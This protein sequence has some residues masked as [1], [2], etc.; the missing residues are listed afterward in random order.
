MRSTVA[1]LLTT[2]APL[3]SAATGAVEVWMTDCQPELF[4]EA[5]P[6]KIRMTLCGLKG[7]TGRC[8]VSS[9]VPLL[10]S[11]PTSSVSSLALTV[12][13]AIKSVFLI[14]FVSDVAAFVYTKDG[15]IRLF[16]QDN[17]VWRIHY[18]CDA[19]PPRVY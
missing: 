12:G 1:L 15:Y 18:S 14:R 2:L 16:V 7:S 4:R 5:N 17:G 8:K 11:A 13:T 19:P 10:G 3:S 6:S 9:R